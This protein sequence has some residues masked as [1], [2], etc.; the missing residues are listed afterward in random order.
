MRS[1]GACPRFSAGGCLRYDSSNKV[2]ILGR[3]LF[4]K[5]LKTT[6]STRAGGP[7]PIGHSSDPGET[8]WKFSGGSNECSLAVRCL[9]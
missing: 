1:S 3:K 8:P 2:D 4:K 9:R 7:D 5:K 6:R